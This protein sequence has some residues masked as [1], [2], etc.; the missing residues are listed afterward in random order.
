MPTGAKGKPGGRPGQRLCGT[1]LDPHNPHS[2]IRVSTSTLPTRRALVRLIVTLPSDRRA[3]HG[4]KAPAPAPAEASLAAGPGAGGEQERP[5][6]A[7]PATASGS[8]IILRYTAFRAAPLSGCP[9]KLAAA[10][11]PCILI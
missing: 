1:K 8:R 10:R 3:Q 6:G 11:A 2:P 5:R 7:P 4:Q 9:P